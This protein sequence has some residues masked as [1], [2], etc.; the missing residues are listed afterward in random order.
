MT[1]DDLPKPPEQAGNTIR[2]VIPASVVLVKDAVPIDAAIVGAGYDPA[3]DR[4]ELTVASDF[5][6]PPTE[7]K[8][9]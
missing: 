7:S 5:L 4:I 9:K 2:V 8:P 1:I 6:T 3:T